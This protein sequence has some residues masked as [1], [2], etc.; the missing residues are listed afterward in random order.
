MRNVTLVVLSPLTIQING[1]GRVS[2]NLNGRNLEVTTVHRLRAIPDRD[3]LFTGWTGATN[4]TNAVIDFVMQENAVLIA[5]FVADPFAAVRG[6]YN[7]L[8]L[9]SNAITH[10]SSG[11]FT[12]TVSRRDVFSGHFIVGGKRYSTHGRFDEN[13]FA[14]FMLGHGALT[15]TLQLDMTYGTDQI[16]GTLTDGVFN[17]TLLGDLDVFE[18]RTAPSPF[19]GRYNL[20]FLANDIVGGNGFATI[21]INSDGDLQLVGRLADGRVITQSVPVSKN[22]AWA[23]YIPLYGDKG[24]VISWM[25][26]ANLPSSSVSGMVNWFRPAH[27][28]DVFFPDGFATEVTAIGSLFIIPPP[29]TPMLNWVNGIAVLGG[30]NLNGTITNLVTFNSNNTITVN[31]QLASLHL[32]VNPLG[33]LHGSFVHPMSQITESLWGAVLPK[34]NWAGGFFLDAP[35]SGF[36]FLGQD[37]S[38]GTNALIEPP[39]SLSGL[40]LNV[41]PATRTGSFHSFP[42]S[43]FTFTDGTFTTDVASFGT[44]TFNF[45]SYSTTAADVAELNL[46][47]GTI[48]NRQ[49][50]IRVLLNFT[51]NSAGTFL[52]EITAGGEGVASGTFSI[53]P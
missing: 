26:F 23:F 15:G 49:A 19:A 27:A 12:V 5:N 34:T 29:R 20:N 45:S 41:S 11:F 13:G 2:P 42:V 6:D 18:M 1:H 4:S 32:T 37:L 52:A 33:I 35:Q 46:L 44:G 36:I 21:R 47:G 39:G 14:N 50:V 25:S 3:F 17:S 53:A 28:N 8:I 48:H 24:S 9:T 22:G 40:T 30:N 51:S 31:F 7:G 43:S 16:T 10:A 38:A